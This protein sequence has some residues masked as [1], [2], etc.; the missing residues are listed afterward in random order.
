MKNS[1]R[2]NFTVYT[3]FIIVLALLAFAGKSCC[4]SGCGEGYSD[5]ERSGLITKFSKKGIWIKSWEGELVMSGAQRDSN[6]AVVANIFKFSVVD[7]G[8][9]AAVQQAQRAGQ[10]VT[11]HYHRWMQSPCSQESDY[12]IVGV[13]GAAQ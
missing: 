5:G 9:V 7:S 1:T 2:D 4:V 3:I 12:T 10:T 11:L 13:A 8:T 6:G